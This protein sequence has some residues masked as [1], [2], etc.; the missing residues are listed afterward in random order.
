LDLTVPGGMGGEITMQ[1]LLELDSEIKGIVSSGYSD[2]PVLAE[3]KKFG[4]IGK[5]A[6][7]Y[8]KIELVKVLNEILK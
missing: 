2:S 7:P 6:K 5:I 3:P 8:R 1:K 4:F